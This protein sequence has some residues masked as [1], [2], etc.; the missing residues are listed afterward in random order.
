MRILKKLRL[1][2]SL[3][4]HPIKVFQKSSHHHLFLHLVSYILNM[5][6]QTSPH[7][8]IKHMHEVLQ[9]V[10]HEE[11]SQKSLKDPRG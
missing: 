11:Y 4:V 3:A 7:L 8:L 10:N 2:W 6:L 9:Q 5:S 1:I